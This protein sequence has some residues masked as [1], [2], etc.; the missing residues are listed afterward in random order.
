M[1]AGWIRLIAAAIF[2]IGWVMGLK[3]AHTP[4][5]WGATLFCLCCSTYFIFSATDTLPVGTA[6]A[7]FVGL[8]AL[9]ATASQTFIFHAP[10]HGMQLFWVCLLMIGVI[11]LKLV[12]KEEA[13][14]K[15]DS[16]S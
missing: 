8:G 16:P 6:Y 14:T 2:E 12:T 15:E 7:V 13:A 11:G 5:E 3:Y 1:Q 4:L 10:L 9:G